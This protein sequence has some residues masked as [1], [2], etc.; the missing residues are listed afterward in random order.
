MAKH[1]GQLGGMW[2][3]EAPGGVAAM[4]LTSPAASDHRLCARE[5][6]LPSKHHHRSVCSFIGGWIAKPPQLDRRR[7]HMILKQSAQ[8][9]DDAECADCIKSMGH[10]S[11]SRCGAREHRRSSRQSISQGFVT[12]HDRTT[13]KTSLVRTSLVTSLIFLQ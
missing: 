1:G 7:R 12:V 11:A 2:V 10:L 5:A 13:H 8:L 6:Q 4:V 3:A 9:V